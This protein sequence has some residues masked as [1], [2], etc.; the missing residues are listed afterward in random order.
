MEDEPVTGS[1][2]RRRLAGPREAGVHDIDSLGR[3][4]RTP[5][6]GPQQPLPLPAAEVQN[7]LIAPGQGPVEEFR[8]GGVTERADYG[9]GG[10]GRASK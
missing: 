1:H 5:G 2:T 9:V 7:T 6:E 3:H 8:H 4:P 10:A